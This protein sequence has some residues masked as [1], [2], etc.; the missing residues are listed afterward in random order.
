MLCTGCLHCVCGAFCGA[1]LLT[2]GSFAVDL[3]PDNWSSIRLLMPVIECWCSHLDRPDSTD[4]GV[5]DST[6]PG[7]F[8]FTV[9]DA[10]LSSRLG[11]VLQYIE[12]NYAEAEP[13]LRRALEW[14]EELQATPSTTRVLSQR[15]RSYNNLRAKPDDVAVAISNLAAVLSNLGR[16]EEAVAMNARALALRESALP[17]DQLEISAAKANLATSLRK[18]GRNGEAI[19]IHEE[20]LKNRTQKLGTEHLV[21]ASSLNNLA[22]AYSDSGRH[23]EAAELLER[24]LTIRIKALGEYHPTVAATRGNLATEYRS[25]GRIVEA[26]GMHI[27][28][29]E[30]RRRVLPPEHPDIAATMNNLAATYKENGQNR[31]AVAL[32]EE[33]RDFLARVLPADHPDQATCLQNLASGYLAIGRHAEAVKMFE[34]AL[35]LARRVL[36]PDHP[37]IATGINNLAGSYIDL[38]LFKKAIK[39]YRE[40][41]ALRRQVLPEGHPDTCAAMSNLASALLDVGDID[42]AVE[43]HKEV[44]ALRL[45][46]HPDSDPAVASA[47]HNLGTAYAVSG[48]P[49]KAIPLLQN[50][51][52]VRREIAAGVSSSNTSSEANGATMALSQTLTTLAGCCMKMGDDD[53]AINAYY[54][55][56]T[57]LERGG[58]T[59]AETSTRDRP[60]LTTTRNNLAIAYRHAGRPKEAVRMFQKVLSEI[61]PASLRAIVVLANLGYALLQ[62]ERYTEAAESFR[63]SIDLE[64]QG[65]GGQWQLSTAEVATGLAL[66]CN[67]L[68][69]HDEAVSVQEKALTVYKAELPEAHP[70]IITAMNSLAVSYS[71]VRQF[72]S[73]RATLVEAL[74]IMDTHPDAVPVGIRTKTMANLSNLDAVIKGEAQ[75][76]AQVASDDIGLEKK[77]Q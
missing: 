31:E 23:D 61:D 38:G 63:R 28:V 29:L 75:S 18:I 39:A 24:S 14:F 64:S 74:A 27:E 57:E 2:S 73:A 16:H 3:S 30:Y 68:K 12:G 59:T 11:S 8:E 46:Q 77:P 41:L 45:H 32:F 60:V 25:L 51:R 42:E 55:A 62:I 65:N 33:V 36:P 53:G 71:N 5:F 47:T 35:E 69:N 52:D 67:R 58:V 49:D 15:R 40:S 70:D 26:V 34:Q 6:D 17:L 37:D 19:V 21:V 50:A 13:V 43:L 4:P 48:R 72:G 9:V 54:E 44:L 7:V 1:S 20:V 66:A 22:C 76:R 10:E 56:V